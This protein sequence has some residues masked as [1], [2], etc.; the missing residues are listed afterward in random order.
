[1]FYIDKLKEKLA[2]VQATITGAFERIDSVEFAAEQQR[3]Y[4]DTSIYPAQ[5][6]TLHGAVRIMA[7]SGLG[8]AAWLVDQALPEIAWGERCAALC[9]ALGIDSDNIAELE[10]MVNAGRYQVELRGL[11]ERIANAATEVRDD[12]RQK[13]FEDTGT[14]LESAGFILDPEDG[15]IFLRGAA[16]GA[17]STDRV[18]IEYKSRNHEGWYEFTLEV[19]G[20][21]TLRGK[22]GEFAG[23][24]TAVGIT[25]EAAK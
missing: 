13:E 24:L 4:P 14:A 12:A 5:I 18:L 9:E 17:P 19:D 16:P 25:R 23:L 1:M 20:R 8:H 10:T 2:E 6:G 11:C 15:N 22:S 7:G 3:L 21:E